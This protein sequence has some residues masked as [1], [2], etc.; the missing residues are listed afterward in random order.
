MSLWK[1]LEA[2]LHPQDRPA[3]AAWQRC[4]ETKYALS[5][6]LRPT[7]LLEI[8]VRAGY[9]AYCFLEACPN[10]RYLGI[11][12]NSDTHGGFAG[13]IEHA[14]GLLKPYAA[15]I[16]EQSSADFARC[17]EHHNLNFD[18]VHVDGDHSAAGCCRDLRL[19]ARCQ[20]RVIVVDDYLGIAAVRDACDGF[21]RESGSQWCAPVV[22]ED[23]HHGLALITAVA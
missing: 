19:A 12:N 22:I 1:R 16:V 18:C 10:L 20:P 13:A 7:S 23:G 2:Q 17:V 21:H 11:D 5:R 6:L 9:S 4:Y 14:R 3:P 15:E 8:G